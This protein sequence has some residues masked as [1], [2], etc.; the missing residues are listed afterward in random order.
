VVVSALND[1]LELLMNRSPCHHWLELKL[2]GRSSNRSAI[3]A[4]VVCQSQSRRQVSWVSSSVG[5]ASSSDLKMHFG[6]GQ[7][8]T[9]EIEIRWPSGI[10]QR[11]ANVAGDQIVRI[12][13][14]ERSSLSA[15]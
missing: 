2:V 15:H 12:T 7:D 5:Y 4:R 1:R 9:A 13:E 14:P 10:K 3:G 11:L 6:L 8:P